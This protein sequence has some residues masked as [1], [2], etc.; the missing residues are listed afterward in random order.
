V[1]HRRVWRVAFAA[2]VALS[3]VILFSPTTGPSGV[4]VSDKLIH[5]VLF[6]A[7]AV[8][9]RLAEVPVVQLGIGLAGYA[10]ASELLQAALPIERD[11]DVRDA[12]AD[13]LGVATGL[14]LASLATRSSA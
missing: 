7:L 12:L 5:F 9:G 4:A 2:V 14:V 11:G 1:T 10:A 8:T 3:L 13:V 6:T